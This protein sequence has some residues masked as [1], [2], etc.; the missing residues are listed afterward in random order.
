MKLT[1]YEHDYEK[2][3]RE[4]EIYITDAAT[5]QYVVHGPPVATYPGFLTINEG[6]CVVG[7]VDA[8]FDFSNVPPHLHAM[9]LNWILQCKPISVRRIHAYFHTNEQHG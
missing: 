4:S 3:R 8:S 9:G 5:S 7:K 2:E 6:G 1:Y